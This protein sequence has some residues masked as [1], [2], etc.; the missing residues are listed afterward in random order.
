MT[1]KKERKTDKINPCSFN[2]LRLPE[3]GLEVSKK[4][5]LPHGMG[6]L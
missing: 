4:A 6:G 3:A 1:K 5:L 2:I